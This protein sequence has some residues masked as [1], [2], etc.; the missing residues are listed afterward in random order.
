MKISVS[1]IEFVTIEK[2]KRLKIRQVNSDQFLKRKRIYFT[3]SDGFTY[4]AKLPIIY[5]PRNE[6]F[7]LLHR[8]FGKI[9]AVPFHHYSEL[10]SDEFN[11]ASAWNNY[12]K[13]MKVEEIWKVKAKCKALI[14][15]DL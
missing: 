4:V 2:F 11:G 15:S 7:T 1:Q 8:G 3:D 13:D 14:Q 10:I 6:R 9:T 12:A 5:G